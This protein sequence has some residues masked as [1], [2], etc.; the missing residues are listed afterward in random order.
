MSAFCEQRHLVGPASPGW[1]RFF[2]GLA[3]EDEQKLVK[4]VQALGTDCCAR[5]Q[6]SGSTSDCFVAF[7]N[8]LA[9]E[10]ADLR[11][12]QKLRSASARR[13]GRALGEEGGQKL[14]RDAGKQDV[15]GEEQVIKGPDFPVEVI[16]G[17]GGA[18]AA[19]AHTTTKRVDVILDSVDYFIP[20][21]GRTTRRKKDFFVVRLQAKSIA[22]MSRIRINRAL[23]YS[24]APPTQRR[25]AERE[26][27]SSDG[28]RLSANELH[29][30]MTLPDAYNNVWYVVCIKAWLRIL[31]AL[32]LLRPSVPFDA[33]TV[34]HRLAPFTVRFAR[35]FRTLVVFRP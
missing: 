4:S 21:E 35:L 19:A 22:L 27:G 10:S 3:G 1:T 28:S 29:A 24:I 8:R 31:V 15:E 33:R 9:R 25:P 32:V 2:E 5:W 11:S 23:V 30:L 7:L 14:P 34:S 20:M 18:I 12:A 16:G 6:G 13:R 26:P 17:G